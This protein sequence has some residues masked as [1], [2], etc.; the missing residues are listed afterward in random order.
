MENLILLGRKE[1][2]VKDRPTF[3]SRRYSGARAWGGPLAESW[4]N[5]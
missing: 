2:E 3:L 5:N 1:A 4:S